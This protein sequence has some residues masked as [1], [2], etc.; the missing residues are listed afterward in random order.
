MAF[1]DD[2]AL[3]VIDVQNDFCPGGALEVPGGDTVVEKI[4]RIADKF[5]VQVFT[6][7][8]HPSGNVSFAATNRLG[9]PRHFVN[10]RPPGGASNPTCV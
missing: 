6:Q 8:L 2:C 4:N 9:D 1:A 10:R 5:Q 7:D 3:I